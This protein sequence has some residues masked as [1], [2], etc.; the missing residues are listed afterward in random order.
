[1]FFKFITQVHRLVSAN[2]LIV[3][4]GPPGSH[5][6]C[7]LKG[8]YNAS[9][10]SSLYCSMFNVPLHFMYYVKLQLGIHDPLRSLKN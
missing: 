4:V 2:L 10:V 1:M 5:I 7:P 6:G 3:M 8:L 9:P